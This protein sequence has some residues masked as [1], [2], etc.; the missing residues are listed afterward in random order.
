MAQ[1]R[2]ILVGGEYYVLASALAGRRPRVVVSHGDTFAVFDLAGDIPSGGSEYGLFHGGTRFLDRFE[3]KLNGRF[4]FLLSSGLAEDSVELETYLSNDDERQDGVVVLERDT[5][6]IR[7]NKLALENRLYERIELHHY[8]SEPLELALELTY[9][10]DFADIFEVRGIDRPSRGRQLPPSV[11]ARKG[12]VRLRYEGLDGLRRE[13]ALHFRPLPGALGEE[14]ASYRFRLAP[15]ET[16]QVDVEVDCMVGEQKILRRHYGPARAVLRQERRSWREEFPVLYTNNEGFNDWLNRSLEDL[17][18][19]RKQ[20]EEGTTVYAGI[21][22]FATLFGRD[23]LIT[24]FE[25]LAFNP[26][27]AAGTLRVLASMQGKEE[28]P[29]REEEPGKILHEVRSGEMANTGEVPFG[30]YYGSADS[31]PLFLVLLS[32]YARRTGDLELVRELWPAALAALAWIEQWGDRDGDGYVEY[33]RKSERGLY[34]QGWKDSRDSV[35]HADG[36]LAKP[37]IALAE[38]QAYVHWALRG[39][40]ELARHL[41]H[42]DDAL[43]W[44]ER[45]VVLKTRFNREFWLEDE[46]TFA[47]A[48]DRDK[49]PCRVVTTNA[50]HCLLGGI[51]EPQKAEATI[52]RLLRDDVFSGWGLRTLSTKAPRYN[53]MAYHNGSVWPH[54]NALAAEGFARYGATERAAKLLT[55]LFDAALATDERRLPELFCGFPRSMQHKPVAYPVACRPQAWAAA[56]VFLLLKAVLG[57]SVDGFERNLCFSHTSLPE[58]LEHLEIQGLDVGGARLDLAVHRGRWGAAVEVVEK[59][60]DVDVIVRK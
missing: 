58:W 42:L 15:G 7:R 11:E 41:G 37:P 31:T 59:R 35:F 30:R 13:T 45:A 19:L 27:L 1:P 38:V 56:S 28:N 24:A 29:E 54:D 57:L 26:R 60:G 2:G 25:V 17:A 4:P 36:T 23:S 40:A 16:V 44:E 47:L 22:W 46:D 20:A 55:A 43:R 14:T 48:L 10:A 6:A 52:E 33:E 5:V 21:P 51:A 34:H 53:P 50:A 9:G 8:G 18:L 3:L 12:I 49:K 32:E 39:M